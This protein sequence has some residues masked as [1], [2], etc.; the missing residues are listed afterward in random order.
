M[1]SQDQLSLCIPWPV[2]P[3]AMVSGSDASPE[4]MLA[5]IILQPPA[6]RLPSGYPV[7]QDAEHERSHMAPMALGTMS[8]ESGPDMKET[9]S[10][11]GQLCPPDVLEATG[12]TRRTCQ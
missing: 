4:T 1:D 9:P 3:S 6:H 8:R 12:G 2:S 11:S 10:P 7:G 5:L